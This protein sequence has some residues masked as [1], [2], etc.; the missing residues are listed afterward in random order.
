MARKMHSSGGDGM[1]GGLLGAS[2][3]TGGGGIGPICTDNSLS[4]NMRHFASFLQSILLLIV[5]GLLAIWAYNN[6]KLIWS[7]VQGPKKSRR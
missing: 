7:W 3:A 4:C 5:L 1:M 2:L 6:R